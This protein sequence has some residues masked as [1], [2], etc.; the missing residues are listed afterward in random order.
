MNLYRELLGEQWNHVS[1]KVKNSHLSG[2]VLRAQCCLDVVGSPNFLGKIISRIVS[3]PAPTKGANVHLHIRSS[4][5]GELWERIFPDRNLQ[6]VQSQCPAGYLIDRFG[7]MAFWF[8]L[9]TLRGGILHNHMRTYIGLGIFNLR[10][11][12]FIS[13]KVVSHEEPD[14]DEEASR[15]KVSVSLPMVGHLLTYSGIVRPVKEHR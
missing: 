4:P 1:P 9:E 3:F 6:S 15:I 14:P 11:P 13:P 2:E 8:R 7:L 12:M 5:E 10:L